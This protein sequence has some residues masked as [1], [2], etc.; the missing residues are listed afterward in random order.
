[1]SGSLVMILGIGIVFALLG[2][3]AVLSWGLERLFRVEAEKKVRVREEPLDVEAV[4]A[5]ALAYHTKRKGAIRMER[6]DESVWMQH[7]RV[8]P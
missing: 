8:Y 3:L 2:I 4:I 7:G 5:V 6:V 1:M